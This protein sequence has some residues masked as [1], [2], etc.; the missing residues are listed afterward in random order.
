MAHVPARG[1]EN[2]RGNVSTWAEIARLVANDATAT[3]RI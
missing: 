3:E 1:S 2:S